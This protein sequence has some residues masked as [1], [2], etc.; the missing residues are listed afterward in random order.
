MQQMRIRQSVA[1]YLKFTAA[2]V[3]LVAVLSSCGSGMYLS[4]ADKRFEEEQYE[5]AIE[6]Y[7]QALK[8]ANNTGEINYRIAEAYRLSNRLAEAEPYYKAA[9]D[10]NYRKEEGFFYYGMALKANGKYEAA[11]GQMQDYA[12]IGSKQQLKTLALREVETL[13]Q[14]SSILK[15]STGFEIYTLEALNT[16]GSDFAPFVRGNEL[17]F[18]STRGPGKT[19]QGNGEGF[20]NLYTTTLGDSA[21][22]G[23]AVRKLEGINTDDLH[24][25]MAT[26][27][28]EGNTMVFARGN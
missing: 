27:A 4:K 21:N 23:A 28:D 20:L 12:R 15:K 22:L 17:I 11:L 3:L 2:L 5:R 7:K 9:L 18:S 10:N 24:E 14:L 1:Y 13:S 16:E 6:F 26:F 8:G 19:Y 25:A